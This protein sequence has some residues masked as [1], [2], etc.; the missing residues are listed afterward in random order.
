MHFKFELNG[1]LRAGKAKNVDLYHS[2][3]DVARHTFS[4]SVGTLVHL[5]STRCTPCTAEEA[6]QIEAAYEAAFTARMMA[7]KAAYYKKVRAL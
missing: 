3:D 2:V 1:T 4:L 5:A 6:A 7:A